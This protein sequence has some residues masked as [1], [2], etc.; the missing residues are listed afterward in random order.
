M[1]DAPHNTVPA[2]K[3]PEW[4]AM[5]AK[6]L[7]ERPAPPLARRT[8]SPSDWEFYANEGRKQR[9]NAEAK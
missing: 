7:A 3:S 4:H 8:F 6:E 2:F 9:E 5:V 1:A